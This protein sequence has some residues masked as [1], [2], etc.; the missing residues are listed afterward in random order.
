MDWENVLLFQSSQAFYQYKQGDVVNDASK[1][2]NPLSGKVYLG[3][4]NDN[5]STAIE[6]IIKVSA[7]K[8]NQEWAARIV[9]KLNITSR[10]EQYL[11]N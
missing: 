2:T 4:L 1:M 3:L 10:Q 7:I 6:V 8:V 9:Q 5:L 11:K